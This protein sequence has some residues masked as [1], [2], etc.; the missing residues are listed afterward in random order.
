MQNSFT[1]R[2]CLFVLDNTWLKNQ[3]LEVRG[4]DGLR[5]FQFYFKDSGSERER[6]RASEREREGQKES[7][8]GYEGEESR[9]VGRDRGRGRGG[10]KGEVRLAE[11]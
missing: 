7:E 3:N 6:R 11:A 10:V 8:R 2:W 4:W 9:G 5:N 1:K